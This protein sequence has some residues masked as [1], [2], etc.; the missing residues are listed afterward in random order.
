MAIT[1]NGWFN[2]TYVRALNNDIALDLGDT[3]PGVYKG[4][5]FKSAVTPNFSQANPAYGSSPWNAN[6]T[7]GPGYTAGGADLTVV[8]FGELATTN[9]VG[10]KFQPVEWTETTIEAEGLLIYCPSLSNVAVLF[11][12]FE[13]L[14]D[15]ADGTLSITFHSDGAWRNVLR[16]TA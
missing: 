8:S 3:T 14:K 5:L 4:A 10:W 2:D 9:K 13:E 16:N 15:T 6:E 11:R 7:S 1:Q 12:W